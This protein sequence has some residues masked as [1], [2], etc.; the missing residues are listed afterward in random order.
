MLGEDPVWKR[1]GLGEQGALAPEGRGQTED[2]MRKRVL[3]FLLVPDASA[4][5]RLRRSLAGAGARSGVVV[6]T[7]PELVE[8]AQ[9][10]YFIPHAPEDS[11]QTFEDAMG[12]AEGAFWGESFSVAPTETAHAVRAALIDLLSAFDPRCGLASAG[13]ERLP[14]RSRR[15]VGDLL[16]LAGSLNGHLPGDLA[17]IRNLLRTGSSDAPQPIRV[18]RVEGIPRTTRWQ[19]ALLRKLNSDADRFAEGRDPGLAAALHSCFR[20]SG[21]A[22]TQSALGVMQAGLFEACEAAARLDAS[23]QWVG[24]RD[25]CQEAEAAAGMVQVLLTECSDLRPADIGLLL[26]DSFAYSV[27]VEDAFQLAGL[28]LSGLP[29]ERW[30]RDLGSEAVYH[31]LFCRQ[32]PAPAMALAVCLSSV[33]MPWSAEEGAVLAQ[34]VMD[35]N[36]DLRPPSGAGREARTMLELLRGGDT[37]PATLAQ[38]LRDFAVLLDGGEVFTLH[39]RRAREAVDRLRAQLEGTQ[40]ID[41]TGLRRGAIPHFI[42]AGESP[43][44]NLEGITVWRESHEPWREVRHLFVLGFAQGCYPADSKTSP[45]FSADDVRAIRE[46]LGVPLVSAAEEQDCLRRRFRRQLRAASDSATFLIPRRHE[47]G[48]MQAPSESLAFMRRIVPVPASR[49]DLIAELDATQDRARIRRLARAPAGAA[50]PPR[51]FGCSQIHLGRDLLALRTDDEG[52]VK[53]ESPTGLE[54]PMI[55]PLA[56]LLRRVG[57]EPLQWAPESADP[58]IIGTLAH[59][60]FEELFRP[61]GAL[62]E[63]HEIGSRVGALLDRAA[64]HLAPFF[65]TP[66]WQVERR[67]LAEQ[68]AKAAANWR[69]TL[70]QLGAEVLGSEQWLEGNWSGVAI[71][72]QTD[73]ILGL[74]GNRLLIVDYKWSKSDSRRKR[75]ECGFDSQASLYRAMVQTGGPKQRRGREGN[76]RGDQNLAAKLREAAWIGIVYFMMKDWVCLSDSDLPGFASVPGWRTIDNDVASNA[77]ALI[78]DRL[79]EFRR[80]VVAL[81]C[82]TDREYFE[83]EAGIRPHAL[84]LSPLIDLFSLAAP[85][86]NE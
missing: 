64:L 7:W 38:A 44:Y 18:Y 74:K 5:R 9:D 25:F 76:G 36:Y 62:P 53:P 15:L 13:C 66:Q 72:G 51:D 86:R 68:A 26:P 67:H 79:D 45:V 2:G 75:M 69:D 59:S 46:R 22:E 3:Q 54:M 81:N 42:V 14:V 30:R 16:R 29:A 57:A 78:R 8:R 21:R 80:G 55:S 35:G 65:R 49:K 47:R 40:E 37:E 24:V 6:G 77:V 60:V 82:V 83:K 52:R 17:A 58:R 63:P 43:S 11:G 73:L 56:W 70:E 41:W 12:A 39:L 23:L 48:H 85:R 61:G 84:D 1:V 32:K 10:A 20:L 50:E 31:F 34:A 27:A 33:L 71:H 19:D 4:A 28:A